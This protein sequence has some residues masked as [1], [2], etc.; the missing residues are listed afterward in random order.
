[1]ENNAWCWFLNHTVIM[2]IIGC[3]SN[4]HY[5]LSDG[6]SVT[7]TATSND[8]WTVWSNEWEDSNIFIQKSLMIIATYHPILQSPECMSTESHYNHCRSAAQSYYTQVISSNLYL[9]RRWIQSFLSD[10][11]FLLCLD[12]TEL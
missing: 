7:F 11:Y 4:N 10:T 6:I 2:E 1:M 8:H 5:S 12:I 9:I 3:Y